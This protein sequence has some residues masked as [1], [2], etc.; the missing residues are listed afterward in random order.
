[1]AA[2]R[3]HGPLLGIAL[4]GLVAGFLAGSAASRPRPAPVAAPGAE[5]MRSE[6]AAA[7]RVPGTLSRAQALARQMA[8]LGPENVSGAARAFEE[9]IVSTRP[10]DLRAL[11]HT[12]ASFAPAESFEYGL[13]LTADAKRRHALMESAHQWALRGGA[14]EA[15]EYV[16]S[17]P[18]DRTRRDALS[19][20]VRG[21]VRSGDVDGVTRYLARRREGS[22]RVLLT[23]DVVYT[24]LRREG[25]EA[26]VR[27]ADA[28]PSDAPNGFKREAFRGALLALAALRPDLAVSWWE[29]QAETP[30]AQESLWVLALQWIPEDPDGAMAWLR[31]LPSSRVRDEAIR[32]ALR[33]WYDTERE[34]ALGWMVR[35]ELPPQLRPQLPPRARKVL[36]RAQG[37]EPDA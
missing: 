37:S 18:G 25:P 30:W 19:G 16:Q 33:R 10:C 34:A 12:W 17:V 15:R 29:T 6:V 35:N 24:V 8:R 14:L 4:A 27:W 5:A 2:A 11:M 9:V 32:Q 26:L 3:R 28:I 13:G 31:S 22:S 36:Q 1:V 23:T 20:L 7:L 21:W